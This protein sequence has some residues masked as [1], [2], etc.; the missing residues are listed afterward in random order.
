MQYPDN[1]HLTCCNRPY[2]SSWRSVWK[3]PLFCCHN[4]NVLL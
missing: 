2:N 3:R 4:Y 1:G